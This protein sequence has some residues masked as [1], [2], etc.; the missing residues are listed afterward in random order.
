MVVL[1]LAADNIANI[2]HVLHGKQIQSVPEQ[3]L[4]NARWLAT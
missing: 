2:L 3:K 1:V 4:Y